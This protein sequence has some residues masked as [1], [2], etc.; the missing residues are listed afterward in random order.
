M[1]NEN[2]STR[3]IIIGG[4]FSLFSGLLFTLNRAMND[5]LDLNFVD[6]LLIVFIFR[7]AFFFVVILCQNPSERTLQNSKEY[8]E[9]HVT[10]P[11]WIYTVEKGKSLQLMRAFLLLQGLFGGLNNLGAFLAVTLMPIGDAHALIFSA[12]LPTMVL[13]KIIFGTR[14][15]LYKFFCG[16]NVFIGIIL[17]AKP[18]Y[19]F[20]NGKSMLNMNMVLNNTLSNV[21]HIVKDDAFSDRFTY[22]GTYTYGVVA[23]L[24]ASLSRGCQAT[25]ISYLHKNE[26]TI[27]ANLIGLYSGLGGFVIPVAAL[28]VN[29][30]EFWTFNRNLDLTKSLVLICIGTFSAIGTFM[31]IKSIELIGS[32]LESFCRTSDIIIAYIIQVILFHKDINLLSLVGSCFII[33]SIMLMAIEKTVVENVQLKCLKDIL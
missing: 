22:T 7:S 9:Y 5:L 32:V 11:W 6:T 18:S 10:Y 17:I 24:L 2:H 28:M 27:S 29:H 3:N 4:S 23:A 26:S 12:P 31:L 25:T 33:M 20:G 14:L 13:S 19:I 15:K 21:E 8:K 16:I 30:E 1:Y